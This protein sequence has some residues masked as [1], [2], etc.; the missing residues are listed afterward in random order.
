[1][2]YA[3]CH[4]ERKH[5]CKGLCRNCYSSVQ[6]TKNSK[7]AKCHPDRPHYGKGLC[8][9]CCARKRQKEMNLR[10][11]GLSSELVLKLALRQ[12]F[13][14]GICQKT[15]SKKT[16]TVDH[17]HISGKA[18]GLLCGRCNTG[19]GILGDSVRGLEKALN[20]LKNTPAETLL[21]IETVKVSSKVNR[22]KWTRKK[23]VVD[24]GSVTVFAG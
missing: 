23:N 13:K 16:W 19:L 2:K 22:R 17:D 11:V 9:S 14:C 21:N 7:M 24:N 8:H 6:K 3:E 10:D 4:P 20:Y 1:M 5:H 12:R 18:R 15:I